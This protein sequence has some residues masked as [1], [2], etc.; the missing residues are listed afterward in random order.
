MDFKVENNS[1]HITIRCN[2]YK[3]DALVAPELKS[4]FVHHSN[5]GV[6][7]FVV[8]LENSIIYAMFYKYDVYLWKN[9]TWKKRRLYF[10]NL[11]KCH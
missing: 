1:N 4:L 6:N 5:N 3:L 11:M 10:L 9:N 7:A 8:D 2:S